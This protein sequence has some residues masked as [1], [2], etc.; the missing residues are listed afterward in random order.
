MWV[1]MKGDSTNN[2]FSAVYGTK[3]V[4]ASLNN[5][6]G[7]YEG[8]EWKDKNGD[9]WLFGGVNG[10]NYENNSLWKY[11]INSNNWT[12]KAGANYNGGMAVY[13]TKGVP[14]VNNTPGARGWGIQCWVDTSGSLW[15]FGGYGMDANGVQGCLNDLWKFDITTSEWTWMSGSKYK[16]SPGNSGTKGVSSPLNM[17]RARNESNCTW[18][19]KGNLWLYGGLDSVWNSLN[20]LWKYNISTNEWTWVWGSVN[21]NVAPNFG[22][23]GMVSPTNDPGGRFSYT[24]YNDGAGNF[25]F[26]GNGIS[27]PN[28]LLN[29]VWKYSLTNND[30]TWMA[31]VNTVYYMGQYTIKCDT[32]AGDMPASKYEMRASWQHPSGL[33]FFGGIGNV[34]QYAVQNDLWHY[35]PKNNLYTWVSGGDSNDPFVYGRY[36]TKGTPSNSNIP[37]ART[38]SSAWTDN[39]GDLWLYGGLFWDTIGMNNWKFKNDLWKYSPNEDCI[40]SPITTNTTSQDILFDESIKIYP[41]PTKNKLN[42]SFNDDHQRTI[43]I[44]N[45]LGE[46]VLILIVKNKDITL[47]TELLQN[48]LYFLEINKGSKLSV[49]KIIIHK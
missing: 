25:Y 24:K 32:V 26:L 19:D 22:V 46:D 34:S 38:G 39:S 36:G 5:P 45:V 1:W 37:S 42:I 30:W 11:D 17:P 16:C 13:G 20:D 48:G 35:N 9:F 29:D 49:H 44:M 18:V 47:E 12:W 28:S 40:K 43:T 15:L 7:I 14:S 2:L 6:D 41:N 21:N 31:G 4:A 3:N 23:K 10:F 33:Y 8:C 27:Y